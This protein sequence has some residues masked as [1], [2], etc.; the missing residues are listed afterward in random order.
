MKSSL[1]VVDDAAWHL[2]YRQRLRLKFD[3]RGAEAFADYELL[4]MLLFFA[5]QRRDVKP[6]VNQLLR[7]FGSLLGL[8]TAPS[9]SLLKIEGI[10]VSTVHL[11]KL[12]HGILGHT[13]RQEL[14][15]KRALQSWIQVLHYCKTTMGHSP[16][17]QLRVIFLDQKN[18]IITDEVQQV[19][20][21]NQTAV[22]PRE[23]MKRALEVGAASIIMV[24]NHPSGDPTPSKADIDLTLKIQRIG[25]DLGIILHDHLIIAH[26]NYRSFKDMGIL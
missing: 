13:L 23:I 20:T 14:K 17:E 18:Q 25:R 3:V 26:D 15:G 12:V 19:G 22:Y 4:E 1:L 6:L 10:G 7:K 11:L 8:L 9:S 16:N 24:H 21:I 2:S 5:H